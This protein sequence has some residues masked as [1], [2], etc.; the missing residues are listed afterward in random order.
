[1]YSN[2]PFM[3]V[4]VLFCI[5]VLYFVYSVF[6]IVF[7]YCFSFRAAPLFTIP[8]QVYRPLPQGGIPIAVYKYHI[9]L[10][11]SKSRHYMKK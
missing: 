2:I 8:V 9:Y 3:F 5:L 11:I 4:F 6:F 1:M 10:F 7:V